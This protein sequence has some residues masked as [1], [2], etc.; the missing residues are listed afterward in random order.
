MAPAHRILYVT[1]PYMAGEDVD[2]LQHT[3]SKLGYHPGPVD[4]RYGPATFMAVERLQAHE[5]LDV[6]GIVGPKTWAALATAKPALPPDAPH[7]HPPRPVPV[8]PVHPVPAVPVGDPGVL[9]LHWGVAHLGVKESPAG[10][11]HQPFSPMIGA[12]NN[13]PWCDIF[14]S[15]CLYIGAHYIQCQGMHAPGVIAKGCTYV[16]TTEAWLRAHNMWVGRS[17]PQPG[18]IAIFNWDGGLADH[19][20]IVERYLG[21]GQFLSIE[22]NT[23]YGNNSNG[24]ESMRRTRY[25]TQVDGFGKLRRL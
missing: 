17:Q 2:G 12:P 18:Y 4:G 10:S 11:N 20:G 15:C 5:G 9:A 19:V 25:L 1:S 8:P 14:V 3:L 23:S 22:G 21:G 24:G 7:P 16:P 13:V 6:D